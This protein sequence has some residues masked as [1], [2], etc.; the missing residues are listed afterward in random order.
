M[1]T[2]PSAAANVAFAVFALVTAAS[3]TRMTLAHPDRVEIG[4]TIMVWVGFAVMAVDRFWLAPRRSRLQR[5]P[6]Q[7]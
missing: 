2:K 7:V 4:L 1:G 3:F 5:P 6:A